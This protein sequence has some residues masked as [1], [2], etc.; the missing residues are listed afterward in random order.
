M[1]DIIDHIG[2][3]GKPTEEQF[4]DRFKL[5][6]EKE[7]DIWDRLYIFDVEASEE[8]YTL[9]RD[10]PNKVYLCQ[11]DADMLAEIVILLNTLN[12]TTFYEGYEEGYETA[13]EEMKKM[14]GEDL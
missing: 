13:V 2:T 12:D 11:Q 3:A 14:T 8:V 9:F 1:E 6:L 5:V 4:E 10:V 7:G